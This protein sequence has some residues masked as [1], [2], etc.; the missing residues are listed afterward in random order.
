MY[1]R[2][3]FPVRLTYEIFAPQLKDRKPLA[4]PGQYRFLCPDGSMQLITNP[5]PC[6]WLQQPWNAVVA[7]RSANHPL[8]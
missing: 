1:S 2:Y 4:D 5:R 6:A 7:R 3:R 8:P